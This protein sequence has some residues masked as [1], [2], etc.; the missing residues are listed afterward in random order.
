MYNFWAKNYK[1]H[2]ACFACR[3]VFRISPFRE[4]VP[5][6]VHFAAVIPEVKCPDCA[7]PMCDMGLA[8][9]APRRTDV[10]SWRLIQARWEAYQATHPITDS[11]TG[12]PLSS[13][14]LGEL[15][16]ERDAIDKARELAGKFNKRAQKNG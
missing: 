14:E 7:L 8:F 16:K 9:K 12:H 4:W 2:F 11:V 15:L 10:K 1:M 5:P 6:E 3:K 13:R